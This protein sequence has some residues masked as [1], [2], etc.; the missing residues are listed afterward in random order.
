MTIYGAQYQFPYLFREVAAQWIDH[1][2]VILLY[3]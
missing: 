2:S 1:E 3:I